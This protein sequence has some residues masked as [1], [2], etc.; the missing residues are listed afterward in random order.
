MTFIKRKGGLIKKAME[1]S[2]LCNCDIA[3]IMYSPSGKLIKY[4]STDVDKTLL[5][6]TESNDAAE[7]HTNEDVSFFSRLKSL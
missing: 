4:G 2:V 5:K 3:L 1:L 7:S 6:Y